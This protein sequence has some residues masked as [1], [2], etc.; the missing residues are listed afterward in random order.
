MFIDAFRRG[1][2]WQD[3]ASVDLDHAVR[4]EDTLANVRVALFLLSLLVATLDPL[5][6]TRPVGSL[7]LG[8]MLLYSLAAA[9]PPRGRKVRSPRD[10]AAFHV[11]DTGGVLLALVLTGGAVSPFSTLFLFVL[12]AAG[13]RWGQRET[14][15]TA[16][17]GVAGP[18]RQGVVPPAGPGSVVAGPAHR[19]S[20]RHLRRHRRHPHRLHGRD[21]AHPALTSAWLVSRILGRMQ[22]QAGLVA[23]VQAVLDDLMRPVQGHA[24]RTGL[25]RR[26]QQPHRRCGTPNA[27][28]TRRTVRP[29]A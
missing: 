16:A 5:V 14:W 9:L 4:V 19:R 10:V 8:V 24:R 23:A 28:A 21:R 27:R 18:G 13:Y 17:A 6:A 20:A 15:M 7:L 22:P 26:R 2:P 1:A 11:V 25:R 29:S 12:L 3:S